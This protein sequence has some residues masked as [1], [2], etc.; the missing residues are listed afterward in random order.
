MGRLSA[1]GL[2]VT[3]IPWR[4]AGLLDRMRL[5]DHCSGPYCN[6]GYTPISVSVAR[7]IHVLKSVG[8]LPT[9]LT[10]LWFR[11]ADA[12]FCI[13]NVVRKCMQA[14]PVVHFHRRGSP[15]TGRSA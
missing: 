3:D 6:Y 9:L 13:W 4:F 7:E 8:L 12:K 11:T 10:V 1:F 2:G 15:R 5:M 14:V